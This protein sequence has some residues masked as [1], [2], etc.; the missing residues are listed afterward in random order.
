MLILDFRIEFFSDLYMFGT[1]II[2]G[3]ELKFRNATADC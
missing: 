2:N 1:I 3:C